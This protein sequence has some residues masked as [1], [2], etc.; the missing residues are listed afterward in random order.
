MAIETYPYSGTIHKST[1]G[2]GVGRNLN[3][4]G[5]WHPAVSKR[6]NGSTFKE[7]SV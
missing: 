5:E 7:L 6:H 4:N 1:I 3:Y 2:D